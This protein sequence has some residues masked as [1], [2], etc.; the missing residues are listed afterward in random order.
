MRAMT[1][2]EDSRRIR[3][4]AEFTLFYL[5]VPLF[6]ALVLPPVWMF[7]VLFGVTAIGLVLLH[8]SDGFRWYDLTRGGR[9][10]RLWE[11]TLF[12]LITLG[13]GLAVIYGTHP[14]AAF[15][16]IR[17]RPE[18]MVMIFFLYPILSALPQE[19]V[20]RPLFFRRY[21]PLL[22]ARDK[23]IVL[24]AGLFSLAHL[25]YW[26][27][28]VAIM[29]F[30]GGLVFA[31]VYETRRSFPAAVILHSVAGWIIFALGLGVYFYSG[32]VQRPF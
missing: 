9:E 18:V 8:L 15:M 19:L 27:W 4:W 2:G 20:F 21:G 12:A 23:A 11:V 3:L 32:N 7:P 24:N 31:W 25:M 22:P 13:V 30:A 10:L 5:G 17:Q 16:L 28:V 14:E 1:L 29:T 26:S 6:M